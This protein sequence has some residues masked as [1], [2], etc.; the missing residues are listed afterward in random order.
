M[1]RRAFGEPGVERRPAQGG[2]GGGREAVHVAAFGRGQRHLDRRPEP[3]GG[4]R[5]DRPQPCARCR[6][7]VHGPLKALLDRRSAAGHGGD[8][9]SSVYELLRSRH[10]ARRK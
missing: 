2:D 6:P 3:A 5:P 4:G 10:S 7:G 9:V 8:S 1:A